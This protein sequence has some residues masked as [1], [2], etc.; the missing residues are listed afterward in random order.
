[1]LCVFVGGWV[2]EAFLGERNKELESFPMLILP[3]LKVHRLPGE[4]LIILSQRD[5]KFKKTKVLGMAEWGNRNTS[6]SGWHHDPG[7][8]WCWVSGQ[9]GEENRAS[10][11]AASRGLNRC[12][13]LVSS[14]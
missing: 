4:V 7:H 9:L 1:M 2:A 14:S 13:F 5:S 3:S 8:C 12:L 10:T 6:C 11:E